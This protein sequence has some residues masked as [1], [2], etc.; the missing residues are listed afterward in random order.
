MQTRALRCLLPL[1]ASVTLL[2]AAP[3][4]LA[5]TTA[6]ATA[7][8]VFAT[9]WK[10]VNAGNA[11]AAAALLAPSV[12]WSAGPA[13][14]YPPKFPLTATGLAGV[15][16][17]LAQEQADHITLTLVGTPTVSGNDVSFAADLSNPTLKTL[18]VNSVQVDGT[19]TVAGGL[20]TAVSTTVAP[21]SVAAL[22]KAY[23]AG[24]AAAAAKTAGT[25]AAA[26]LP[27]TGAG[28]LLWVWSSLLL[29]SGGVLLRLRPATARRQRRGAA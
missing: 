8:T 7:G 4:A 1:A 12:K 3:T 24:A 6:T 22:T 28:P 17:L 16:A 5:A 15:G 14:A 19:A 18:G 29:L 13:Q 27:K 26:A 2:V 11:T 23:G 20:I 21:A 10:D 25:A 9:F